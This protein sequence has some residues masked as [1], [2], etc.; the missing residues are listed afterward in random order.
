MEAADNRTFVGVVGLRR[1]LE[2]TAPSKAEVL[3][4]KQLSLQALE[5]DSMTRLYS[6]DFQGVD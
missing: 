2:V 6:L 1:K 3:E 4:G 5:Q